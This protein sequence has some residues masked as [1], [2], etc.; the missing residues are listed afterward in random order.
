MPRFKV[1]VLRDANVTFTAEVEA[2]S[3]DEIKGH[4]SRYGDGGPIIGEWEEGE[5]NVYDN[6]ERYTVLDEKGDEIYEEERG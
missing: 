2:N 4:M 6:V 3:L 1:Q 5:A